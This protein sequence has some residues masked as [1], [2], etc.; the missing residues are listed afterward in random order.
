MQ[1]SQKLLFIQ[2]SIRV[3]V[4]T[5][6]EASEASQV[7]LVLT[8][9]EVLQGPQEVREEDLNV[10]VKKVRVRQLM[11]ELGLLLSGESRTRAVLT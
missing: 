4:D 9:L 6:E 2:D 10:L 3:G 11:L 5:A 7:G 8:H 1:Q